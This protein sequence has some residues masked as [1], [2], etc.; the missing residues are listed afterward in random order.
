[1]I[2]EKLLKLKQDINQIGQSWLLDNVNLDVIDR[3]LTAARLGESNEY[4]EYVKQI[5]R[6]TDTCL[7]G[8]QDYDALRGLADTYSE[9]QVFL[10]LNAIGSV[11]RVREDRTP[12]PDFST[13]YDS[14][15]LYLELK[16]MDVVGGSLKHDRIM[17]EALD[18]RIDLERQLKDGRS[19]A[20]SEGSVAPYQSSRRPYNP[21]STKLVI[22]TLVRKVQQVLKSEQFLLGPTVLI[23]DLTWV[24][25]HGTLAEALQQRSMLAYAGT[26]SEIS[27]ELWHVAFGQVGD[28]L[29]KPDPDEFDCSDGVLEEEGLLSRYPFIQALAFFQHGEFASATTDHTNAEVLNYLKRLS[30]TIVTA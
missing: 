29:L 11:Q 3:L 16:T 21:Y 19:I 10:R 8:I 7:A 6:W 17:R 25:L 30:R 18:R 15:P 2:R 13:Y 24:L 5:E 20:F 23:L 14:T 22:E 9:A 27:G 26:N 1:M 4:A 28:T 12:K